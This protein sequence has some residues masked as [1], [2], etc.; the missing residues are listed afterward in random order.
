[1]DATDVRRINQW[2]MTDETLN[3]EVITFLIEVY[4]GRA[5]EYCNNIFAEDLPYTVQEFIAKCI[6][7]N[8]MDLLKQRSMG[9]VSYTYETDIPKSLFRSLN[10][11]RR[12][13][14]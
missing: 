11:Y 6:K 10:I 5:E 13:R 12:L 14:W 8:P 2:S 1:M 9:E 4:R 7:L 3:D